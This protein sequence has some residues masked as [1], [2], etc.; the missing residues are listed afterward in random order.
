[1]QTNPQITVLLQTI[2]T[3]LQTIYAQ[4]LAKVILFGSY[5]RNE[6]TENSDIDILLVFDYQGFKGAKEISVAM[7]FIN[8][9]L[10][11]YN[12]LISIVPT[13]TTIFENSQRGLFRNIK[14]D[15][16]EL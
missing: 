11:Q 2:K 10:L 9:F 13:T 16:I 8:D 6:A 7:S 5:A 1:M 14:K 3:S 4:R 12:K 15:G